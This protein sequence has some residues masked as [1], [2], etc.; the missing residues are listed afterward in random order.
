ME[1]IARK[2]GYDVLITGVLKSNSCKEWIMRRNVDGVIFLGIYHEMFFKEVKMLNIPV[3]LIDTYEKIASDFFN[4]GIDDVYGG[5]IATKH[6]LDLG[7]RNI[8]LV[9]GSDSSKVHIKRLEGYKKAL[10][11]YGVEFNKNLVFETNK[12]SFDGGLNLG[13]NIF[14]ALPN[15]TA[16]F[17]SAD[18]LAVG[19]IKAFKEC[20]KNV[21]ED[22][23][24]VGF[25]DI[26]LCK[27]F[28]PPITTVRQ[29][30]FEKGI[31]A[32]KAIINEIEKKHLTKNRNI[33]LDLSLVVRGSTQSPK[34]L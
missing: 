4:I 27:Y 8:V 23:S 24:I 12:V 19:L 13:K 30:I 1:Y 14:K 5:Y 3:V 10:K 18:V 26:D 20:N 31:N 11:E 28:N 17:A 7:H 29:D 2:K 9:I 15:V 6:L 32:S 21:P 33:V 25:D 16:V 22:I 34:R